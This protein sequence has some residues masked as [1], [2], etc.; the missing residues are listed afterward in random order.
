MRDPSSIV[1]EFVPAI[2]IRAPMVT[3]IAPIGPMSSAAAEA[4][5]VSVFDRSGSADIAPSCTS[6]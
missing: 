2:D 4:I 6:T 3:M 1:P 5:G